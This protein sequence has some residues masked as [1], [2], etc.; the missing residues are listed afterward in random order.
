[1]SITRHET[2]SER[3][4]GCRCRCEGASLAVDGCEVGDAQGTEHGLLGLS[5]GGC[6]GLVA[7]LIYSVSGRIAA[8]ATREQDRVWYRVCIEF[9]VL[10]FR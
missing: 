5:G 6:L 7:C 8:A 9:S 3:S 4:H 2:D 1:M 10:A